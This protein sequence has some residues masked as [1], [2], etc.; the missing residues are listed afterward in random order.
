VVLLPSLP[1]PI[2]VHSP[3]P[4]NPLQASFSLALTRSDSPDASAASTRSLT[5][6]LALRPPPPRYQTLSPDSSELVPI[7]SA[8]EFVLRGPVPNRPAHVS[9]ILP[10]ALTVSTSPLGL[11]AVPLS[12]TD[13]HRPKVFP[14]PEEVTFLAPS[15]F[16]IDA[17][18]WR[19]I[20]ISPA[21]GFRLLPKP[22]SRRAS[23]RPLILAPPSVA[24]T[25]VPLPFEPKALST[26]PRFEDLKLVPWRAF[27]SLP[28]DEKEGFNSAIGN[29]LNVPVDL[30]QADNFITAL[31][32]P[33]RKFCRPQRFEGLHSSTSLTRA[34]ALPV[35]GYLRFHA[36]QP[37][38]YAVVASTFDA[39]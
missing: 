32:V 8:M 2:V 28:L 12:M 33:E 14:W 39:E 20:R 15:E 1:P 11:S 36:S 30:F 6:T 17:T 38:F 37:A 26:L 21:L 16:V 5:P 35:K 4:L 3:N 10:M 19:E 18:S 9:N 22:P 34:S 24:S 31:P 27:Y 7:Y 25:S 29:G 13:S 23:P